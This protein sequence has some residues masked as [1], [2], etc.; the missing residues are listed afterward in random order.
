MFSQA[1]GYDWRK[2]NFGEFDIDGAT[3]R[4]PD[5]WGYHSAPV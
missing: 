2:N 4:D 5:L 1:S 3:P